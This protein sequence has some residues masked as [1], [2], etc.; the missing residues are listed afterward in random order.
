MPGKL[1]SDKLAA[2]YKGSQEKYR[3]SNGT[4]GLEF[5]DRWCEQC[6]KDE[7]GHRE[8]F[9]HGCPILAAALAFNKLQP[10][11]PPQWVH[12]DEGQPC[13]RAFEHVKDLEVLALQQRQEWWQK[14]QKHQHDLFNEAPK[15]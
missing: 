10:G 1:Y 8:D 13:C 14:I 7:A 2:L 9:K 12:D 15:I 3:P 5:Q 6:Q 4:E 11:Y